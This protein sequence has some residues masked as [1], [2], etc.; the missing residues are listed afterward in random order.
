MAPVIHIEHDT[1]RRTLARSVALACVILL[2]LG[3]V[4]TAGAV[5]RETVLQRSQRWVDLKV[6]YSQSKYFEGYR[7]DCS[8][9]VSMS[10]QLTGVSGAPISPATDTLPRRGV[11]IAKDRLLPGDMIVRPK[12]ATTGGHAVIFGGWADVSRTTYWAFEQSGSHG[13]ARVRQTPYP[14]WP[15]P[16]LPYTPYRYT[17]ITEEYRHTQRIAGA[18]RYSTSVAASKAAFPDPAK[19]DT[20]VLATGEDWPD[21]LGGGALA[22]VTRGPVLL[23]KGASVPDSVIKELKR[24]SPKRVLVIGGPLAISD[25]VLA[26][27]KKDGFKGVERIWGQTR[28]DTA[29]VVAARV[30]TETVAAGRTF[31]GTVYIAT[32]ELFNDALAVSPVA[33]HKG[34]PVLIVRKDAVPDST[35]AALSEIGAKR[36]LMI[37]G[38]LA[39]SAAT[40]DAVVSSGVPVTRIWGADR[41]RTAIEVASH[42]VSE[43]LTRT[44]A[45]LATGA[46]FPD[47]LVAGTALGQSSPPAVL[48]LSPPTGVTSHL[49]S[50]LSSSRT[51]IGTVRVYGGP[52]ALPDQVL[53]ETSAAM[54]GW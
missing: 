17:G 30:V 45:G 11:L 29:A 51:Q 16:G 10:W 14:Y 32:G 15:S 40:R 38:E 24:L 25:D 50:A 34:R 36:A 1:L 8:G 22:G 49:Y 28:Y 19:V 7:T 48:Y 20:V 43:G 46:D 35:A 31:D 6:P 26:Q 52:L 53:A 5:K 12:T 27:L 4:T 18:T 13:G 41:Y 54:R 9:F 42:G 37:G 47:A 2:L 23:T 39:I 44:K 33:V 21:A 3:E